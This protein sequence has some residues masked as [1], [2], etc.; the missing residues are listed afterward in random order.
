MSESLTHKQPNEACW[1]CQGKGWYPVARWPMDA[2]GRWATA[3]KPC[4]SCAMKEEDWTEE[5]VLSN[6][7]PARCTKCKRFWIEGNGNGAIVA[8][9]LDNC[10]CFYCHGKLV[11]IELPRLKPQQSGQAEG[12]PMRP[13]QQMLF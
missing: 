5:Y 4:R 1:R 13:I 6:P 9:S 11:E 12:R 2:D 8:P 10:A 3:R 7:I